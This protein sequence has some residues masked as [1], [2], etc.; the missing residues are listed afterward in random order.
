[1]LCLLNTMKKT[2]QITAGVVG[3]LVFLL[4]CHL[5]TFGIIYGL[6]SFPICKNTAR[7]TIF[8]ENDSEAR[9][10]LYRT[11]AKTEISVVSTEF[12]VKPC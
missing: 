12:L 4:L 2:D 3:I 5:R 11:D 9:Q 1:M 7:I 6:M 8:S 10:L